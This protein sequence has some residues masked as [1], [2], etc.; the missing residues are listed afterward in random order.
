M[1][2]D[3]GYDPVQLARAKLPADPLVRLRS[4][5]SFYR[6][7][8]PYQG[9]GAPRKYGAVFKLG[10][11]TTQGE[12]DA[13]GTLQDPPQA[14]GCRSRS[15]VTCASRAPPTPPSRSR[16]CGS[17]LPQADRGVRLRRTGPALAG[18][19]RR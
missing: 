7:P 5:R 2:L 4:N 10:D 8:G 13:S 16:G 15:G 6:A 3:S 14:D 9:R 12:P 17:S 11:P 18:L 19:D 1:A